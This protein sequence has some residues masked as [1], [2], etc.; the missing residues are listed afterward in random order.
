MTT[1][2]FTAQIEKDAESG[3]YVGVVPNLPGAH[4]QA[5]SLD[6]LHRNLQEVIELCLEE[7]S[8]EELRNLPEFIGVQQVSVTR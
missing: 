5:A 3:L 4:T 1:Y 6:E 7:L 8:A 2:H